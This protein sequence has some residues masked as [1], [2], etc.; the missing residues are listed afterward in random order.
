MF[1]AHFVTEIY[2]NRYW[3][4]RRDSTTAEGSQ[5]MSVV[6]YVKRTRLGKKKRVVR[7]ELRTP[8]C[9]T[10]WHFDRLA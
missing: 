6:V 5:M 3:T 4:P 7:W 1:E 8:G 10:R 2:A 9:E